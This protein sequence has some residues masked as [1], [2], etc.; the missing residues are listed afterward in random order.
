MRIG[1]KQ[2]SFID[3]P[4]GIKAVR[5]LMEKSRSVGNQFIAERNNFDFCDTY[6]DDVAAFR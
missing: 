6:I 1:N 4:S 3:C 2:L 5:R